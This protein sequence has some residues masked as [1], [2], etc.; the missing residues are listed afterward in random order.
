MQISFVRSTFTFAVQTNAKP[1]TFRLAGRSRCPPTQERS[2]TEKGRAARRRKSTLTYAR[3]GA[4]LENTACGRRTGR[5]VREAIRPASSSETSAATYRWHAAV[6][7]SAGRTGRIL[8]VSTRWCGCLWCKKQR[9][10][11]CGVGV[12]EPGHE[13]DCRDPD[14]SNC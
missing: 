6:I 5:P 14:R 9:R 4:N 12:S 1:T 8:A 10:S 11:W 7:G 2:S 3:A 13:N